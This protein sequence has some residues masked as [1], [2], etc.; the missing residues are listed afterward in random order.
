LQKYLK[1]ATISDAVKRG[2]CPGREK[3]NMHWLTFSHNVAEIERDSIF[4]SFAS[5]SFGDELQQVAESSRID[6][7]QTHINTLREYL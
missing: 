1:T 7:I 5:N 2:V 6:S 3:P 4:S